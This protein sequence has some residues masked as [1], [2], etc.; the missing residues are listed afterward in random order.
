MVIENNNSKALGIDKLGSVGMFLGLLGIIGTLVAIFGGDKSLATTGLQS[1]LVGYA[2]WF[3]LTIGCLGITFLHH[4]VRGC[5]GLSI[6]RLVEAGGGALMLIVMGVLFVPIAINMGSLYEWT[7]PEFMNSAE[8]LKHKLPYLNQ[9][10]FFLR[11]GACMLIWI[12]YA[13]YFRRSSL[14]QDETGDTKLA[15]SRTNW[16]APGLVVFFLTTTLVFVDLFMSLDPHWMSQIW[17]FLF[18]VMG[19]LCA[20]ALTTLIVMS[21]AKKEPVSGFMNRG[22]S[23]DLGNFM[24]VFTCLWAYFSFSQYVIIYAGNLPEFNSFYITRRDSGWGLL[25][26]ILMFGQ[27][28]IPFIALLFP[29]TKANP[30]KLVNVAIWILLFRVLDVYWTVMPFMRKEMSFHV[31]DLAAFVGIGGIWLF[32]FSR[33][34]SQT[35]VVPTHD[36]RLI[37]AYEHA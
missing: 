9:S 19:A 26:V 37:T 10:G 12:A 18:V 3:T 28:L 27:F 32:V 1:Y 22:L 14:K 34:A 24:F 21:N 15:Q 25:G 8:A 30:S 7:H 2:F 31:L 5:W 33:V 16:A 20:F 6:L 11:F 23:K 29:T 4:T 36:P 13:S 17:G 35:K